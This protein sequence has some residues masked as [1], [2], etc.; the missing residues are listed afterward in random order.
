MRYPLLLCFVLLQYRS[1]NGLAASTL[2]VSTRIC[3]THK[4][5]LQPRAALVSSQLVTPQ[6]AIN[7]NGETFTPFGILMGLSVFS[8]ACIV[9]VPVI[10]AYLWS[11][12]VD[13]K[14]RCRGVDWIIHFW[15]WASMTLCGYKPE[16]VGLEH[17]D[18]AVGGGGGEQ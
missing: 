17:L 9:Q 4:Q 13:S 2:R 16:V 5:P 14:K 11:H 15:A 7:I 12:A 8:I 1:A 3:G 18:G 6:H 10:L